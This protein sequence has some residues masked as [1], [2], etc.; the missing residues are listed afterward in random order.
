MKV[1]V[2]HLRV[3][4][5]KCVVHQLRHK[6]RKSDPTGME[7]RESWWATGRRSRVLMENG[8][9]RIERNV[10]VLNESGQSLSELCSG[11]DV[12]KPS[13]LVSG[14]HDSAN[15]VLSCELS[16]GDNEGDETQYYSDPDEDDDA[17]N[18]V[19][20]DE[21]NE[22]EDEG[23]EWQQEQQL[24]RRSARVS[25]PLIRPDYVYA[26]GTE[27]PKSHADAIKSADKDEWGREMN[28]LKVFY[29]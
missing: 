26:C 1:D 18:G 10:T 28:S 12:T 27:V 2:G 6:R 3:F 17:A 4:V 24:P 25:K 21:D 14:G 29:N 11:D 8:E 16:S 22:D 7:G 20:Q 15:A 9:V 23:G 5:S 13:E 19:D